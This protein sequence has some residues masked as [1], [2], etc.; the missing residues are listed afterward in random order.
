MV[1][2]VL[3]A[4]NR[5]DP[6][7]LNT[8]I[9][10]DKA[11]AGLG[12]TS[13]LLSII[14]HIIAA[15]SLALSHSENLIYFILPALSI[16]A[17]LALGFNVRALNAVA[18]EEQPSGIR[19]GASDLASF[20]TPSLQA[21][22]S[23][24]VCL[25]IALIFYSSIFCTSHFK[26]Q[27]SLKIKEEQSQMRKTRAMSTFSNSTIDIP[28]GCSGLSPVSMF[29][30]GLSLATL[31]S[32]VKN[33]LAFP[34]TNLIV[35]RRI[36]GFIEYIAYTVVIIQLSRH[37]RKET[38]EKTE[39]KNFFGQLKD[40]LS[41]SQS[42]YERSAKTNSDFIQSDPVKI[43]FDTSSYHSNSIKSD[44]DQPNGVSPLPTAKKIQFVDYDYSILE[45]RKLPTSR[46]QSSSTGLSQSTLAPGDSASI[47]AFL[48][49]PP[50]PP[51]HLR[52]RT[53]HGPHGTELAPL[54]ES[55]VEQLNSTS[56]KIYKKKKKM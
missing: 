26:L 10:I 20:L 34:T 14:F 24:V 2:V 28:N 50:P 41:Y 30:G 55:L 16:T 25:T 54:S 32:L 42:E 49:R 1:T 5:Y 48:P 27:N 53:T 8:F 45:D 37:S 9:A 7:N 44:F 17:F 13:F 36:L 56:P 29:V 19:V 12:V 23:V 3:E 40:S 38:M 46:R 11:T 18:Y 4:K 22:A 35:A 39:V 31:V 15:S 33:L 52:P 51:A 47:A 21:L 43:N 6:G